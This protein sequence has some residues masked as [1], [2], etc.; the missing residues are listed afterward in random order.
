MKQQNNSDTRKVIDKMQSLRNTNIL[1]FN[2][3]LSLIN[4]KKEANMNNPDQ[5]EKTRY[6]LNIPI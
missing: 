4:N 1:N 6:V 5:G 3:Q 2:P